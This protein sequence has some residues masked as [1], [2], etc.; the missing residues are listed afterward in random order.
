MIWGKLLLWATRSLLEKG[1][2]KKIH[3][4]QILQK[5]VNVSHVVIIRLPGKYHWLTLSVAVTT[6]TIKRV[7]SV[8][9]Q[10]FFAT[11]MVPSRGEAFYE[12][13]LSSCACQ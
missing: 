11:V 7:V 2:N 3:P 5:A 8:L 6:T 4:R 13:N 9:L 12:L 10:S 1:D